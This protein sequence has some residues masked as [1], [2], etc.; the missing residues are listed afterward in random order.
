MLIQRDYSQPFLGTR[1]RRRKYSGRGCLTQL[2][3]L[4]LLAVGVFAGVTQRDQIEAAALNLMGQGPTPTPNISDWLAEARRFQ[5]SGDFVRAAAAYETALDMRPDSVDLMV[6]YGLLL[7]DLER[8]DEVVALGDVAIAAD[9]FDPRGYALKA[10]GLVWQGDGSGAIPVALSGLNVDRQHAP[11]YAMLGRAYAL[12]GNLA[13]GIENAEIAV[14]IDSQNADARRA[15]AYTLNYA[16][17]YDVATEQ[18][19]IAVALDPSN[20][21][22]AMELAFQYLS[23]NRDQEAIDLY[24]TVLRAQPRNARAML[25]LCRAYRKVGQ[26][27]EAMAQ[28]EDAV[29]AD[30]TY[31]AAQFQL[32]MIRY[33]EPYRDF[34]GAQASFQACI[35]ADPTNVECLYR[36]GLTHYYLFLQNAE[37]PEACPVA[38]D[39][40][41]QSRQMAESRSDLTATLESINLAVEHVARDCPGNLAAQIPM[42]LTPV[43]ALTL[44]QEAPLLE[45]TPEATPGA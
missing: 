41:M 28:C 8:Y 29:R 25:R 1:R 6:E 5:S 3:L 11:L 37:G 35:D 2:L 14:D 12:T 30:P 20:V 42:N 31:S 38:W 19:E 16:A 43:L 39:M 26:F 23:L 13:A 27:N 34:R 9:G 45:P 22:V 32:G 24:T 33:S 17:A 10:R 15:Y 4:G 44:T 7:I 18:L 21:S 36:L 40:L